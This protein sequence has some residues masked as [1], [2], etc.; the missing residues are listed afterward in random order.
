MLLDFHQVGLSRTTA[1]A[2][3]CDQSCLKMMDL[4]CRTG[5]TR[6]RRLFGGSPT[7]KIALV[8]PIN[9]LLV[10]T[11]VPQ[12]CTIPWSAMADR[13]VVKLKKTA[14]TEPNHNSC[15]APPLSPPHTTSAQYS[16]AFCQNAII[17]PRT[18]HT[19]RGHADLTGRRTTPVSAEERV[20]SWGGAYLRPSAES[21]A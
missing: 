11:L 16:A 14:I 19:Y 15:S 3:N 17:S 13:Y 18:C 2:G 4:R 12:F 10:S 20:G 7:P 6:L 1:T 9:L 21:T 5:R 8:T